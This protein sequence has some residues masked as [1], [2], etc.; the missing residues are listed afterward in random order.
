MT[1]EQMDFIDDQWNARGRKQ[2]IRDWWA[3]RYSPWKKPLGN[4]LKRRRRK[5]TPGDRRAP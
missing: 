1:T 3:G 4:P 2:R 5:V